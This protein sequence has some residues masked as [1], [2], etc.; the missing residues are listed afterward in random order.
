MCDWNWGEYAMEMICH[1]GTVNEYNIEVMRCRYAKLFN[2]ICHQVS[3]KH[4]TAN[5]VSIA[6]H[7]IIEYLV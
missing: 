3:E 4:D 1:I 2:L 5:D 6:A 7:C